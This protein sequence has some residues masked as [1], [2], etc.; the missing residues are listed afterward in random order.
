MES[1]NRILMESENTASVTNVVLQD[2]VIEADLSTLWSQNSGH[3]ELVVCHRHFRDEHQYSSHYFSCQ[4][5]KEMPH[6]NKMKNAHNSKERPKK[7]DRVYI[8][9]SNSIAT[10]KRGIFNLSQTFDC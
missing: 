2:V 1:E 10:D 5:C 4:M 3:L 9:M 7:Y 8:N 6:S